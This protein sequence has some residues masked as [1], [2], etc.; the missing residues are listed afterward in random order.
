MSL[1]MTF[2]DDV[3]AWQKVDPADSWVFDK[4][5]VAKMSNVPCG[6]RGVDVPY[7]AYYCVR[8]TTNV[9]G[10]GAGARIQMLYRNTESIELG[11]FWAKKLDG[12]HISIDYVDGKQV[13][14]VRGTRALNMPLTRFDKWEKVATSIP[15]PEILHGIAKKY[16]VI[17][18]EFIGGTLIEVHLR[19]NLDFAEGHSEMIPRWYYEPLKDI[20]GYTYIPD[21][22]YED[23]RVG[24]YISLW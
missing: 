22:G 6:P 3:E 1:T 14:A 10:N 21:A 4:M 24:R 13:L 16:S 20:E 23:D 12:E 9:L 5:V 15:L 17:N 19:A 8:P 2:G 11:Y 18:C 7:P